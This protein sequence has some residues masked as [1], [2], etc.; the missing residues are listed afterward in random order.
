MAPEAVEPAKTRPKLLVIAT[1][2]ASYPG[3]DA[4]GQTHLE[5]PAGCY[6]L[7]CLDPVIFPEDFYLDCFAKGIDGIIVASSGTDCP[8]EGAYAKTAARIDRVY[9]RM[10]ERGIDPKRLRL[11]AVCSV[12]AKAFLR[13]VER[14]HQVLDELG[15][16]EAPHAGDH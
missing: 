2:L 10:R 13:E 12:C 4:V 1:A 14:M 7:K 3:A 6:V 8:Y 9:Q 5:Y 16:V 11:T 15:P